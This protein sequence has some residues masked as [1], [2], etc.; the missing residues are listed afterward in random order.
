MRLSPSEQD[1]H[2]L[3]AIYRRGGDSS[4]VD[5]ATDSGGGG[6]GD[7]GGVAA[8]AAAVS[9]GGGGLMG[10][11]NSKGDSFDGGITDKRERR[12]ESISNSRTGRCSADL[13][14]ASLECCTI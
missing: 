2:V 10:F 7:L 4:S 11:N 8:G 3:I 13:F 5:P 12:W 6:G 9:N 1:E 14:L